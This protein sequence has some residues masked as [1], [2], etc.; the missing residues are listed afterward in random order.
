M[1]SQIEQSDAGMSLWEVLGEVPDHRD[2]SGQRFQLQSVLAIALA[3]MLAGRSNLAAVARWGRKLPRK[4]LAAFRNTAQTC[5]RRL[6]FPCA[7]EGLE[8][9]SEKRAQAIR[10]MLS[11]RNK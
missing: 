7:V 5:F 1:G 10:L 8:H 6:G 3:A 11:G 2:S 4:G 9:F